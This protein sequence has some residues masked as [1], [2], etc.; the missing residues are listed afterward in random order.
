M[1]K[2]ESKNLEK[3]R[4]INKAAIAALKGMLARGCECYG[5][6]TGDRADEDDTG[7]SKGVRVAYDIAEALYVEKEKRG[8]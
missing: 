5:W 1:D 2:A 8:Y 3:Q 4:F 6:Y 7:K